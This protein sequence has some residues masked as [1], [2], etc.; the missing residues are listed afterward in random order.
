MLQYHKLVFEVKEGLKLGKWSYKASRRIFSSID[1]NR[2]G[3]LNRKQFKTALRRMYLG[4]TA[5][6]VENFM[7][8]LNRIYYENKDAIQNHLVGVPLPNLQSLANECI[9]HTH[10]IN[11]HRPLDSVSS[12]SGGGPLQ[13]K[14]RADLFNLIKRKN[15]SIHSNG[16]SGSKKKK[17]ECVLYPAFLYMFFTSP[18]NTPP[19]TPS[20]LVSTTEEQYKRNTKETNSNQDGIINN[21]D[22]NNNM[23]YYPTS[24]KQSQRR[25]RSSNN[26]RRPSTAPSLTSN[27]NIT[28]KSTQGPSRS[29]NFT[30]DRPSTISESISN[31]VYN[32]RR[33]RPKSQGS[34]HRRVVRTGMKNRWQP[35]SFRGKK[36]KALIVSRHEFFKKKR[37][38][39]RRNENVFNGIMPDLGLEINTRT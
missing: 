36:P 18:S 24:P 34:I 3:Y 2:K 13:R 15:N 30:G 8:L 9:V 16:S 6:D 5:Q 11:Q 17:Q 27:V 32:K 4:L 1:T 22:C 38:N 12:N 7:K 25:V 39:G 19:A 37:R 10:N 21:N 31:L 14:R 20:T 23:H 29:S 35:N 28:K 26:S 33:Q